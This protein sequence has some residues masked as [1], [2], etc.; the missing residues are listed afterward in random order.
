MAKPF[1][2]ASTGEEYDVQPENTSRL[3]K[4]DDGTYIIKYNGEFLR[5]SPDDPRIPK[6]YSENSTR[7]R[8]QGRF[9]TKEG[10]QKAIDEQVR[11]TAFTDDDTLS[12]AL[13]SLS[14]VHQIR[15]IYDGFKGGSYQDYVN[16]LKYHN[17]GLFTREFYDEH[18]WLEV[19]NVGAD[20]GLTL[21]ASSFYRYATTPRI[22]GEGGTEVQR[23]ISY[24]FSPYVH[25]VISGDTDYIAL[26]NSLSKR[27]LKS[28]YEGNSLDGYPVYRQLKVVPSETVSKG[29]RRGL[30]KDN[31]YPTS[32]EGYD[33]VIA[34]NPMKGL[35]I[36]DI[37]GNVG[38]LPWFPFK[39]YAYD[40]SALTP[41]EQFA[42]IGYRKGGRLIP[43]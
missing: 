17:P 23:V 35:F 33:N 15:A 8:Q 12:F 22:I 10:T 40:I 39:Q 42:T 37:N 5:V 34:F 31:F 41:T 21:G 3:G 13:E 36:D 20:A 6:M 4:Q 11:R 29:F 18:P 19:F 28:K 25:K 14:P 2:N 27:V 9:E 1:I 7:Q 26:K 24:P 38:R 32:V 43:R 16:S 30:A